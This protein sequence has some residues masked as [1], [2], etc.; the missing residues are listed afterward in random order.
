ML[1][2]LSVAK[3]LSGAFAAVIAVFLAV[4]AVALVTAS[5]LAEADR[6]NTHTH[7]VLDAAQG[8][9]LGMVNM[10]TGARGFLLSGDDR[11]LEPWDGGQK[12]FDS[13]WDGARRLTADNP[14]QQRRLDEIK[15]R[16]GEFVAVVKGLIQARRDVVAGSKP[17]D[18]FVAAFKQGKDKA[19]MDAFRGLQG[20]F[21]KAE[22]DLLASRAQTA[23]DLRAANRAAI[24]LGALLAIGLS[25]GLGLWVTRSILRQ[26]GGEPDYA[27]GVVR[28]IAQGNLAVEV[29]TRSGDTTSL[30]ADVRAMRDGWRRW[31][32]G[33][34]RA[35]SR[36]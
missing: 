33:C 12:S 19:A 17:M 13:H 25:V 32:A 9:L 1:N 18:D 24:T 26:M 22:R 14:D 31:W 34:A 29:H 7:H 23:D 16:Q 35:R 15:V 28:A 6:W 36:C 5:R 10:E 20:Q 30:L 4:C 11:F 21:D 27:A 8:L 2:N 3:R